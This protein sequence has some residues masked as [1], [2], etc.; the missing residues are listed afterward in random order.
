MRGQAAERLAAA[1][2]RHRGYV[3]EAANVRFRMG[4]LD[5]I[6]L[7]EET[8]CFIEVRSVGSGRFGSALESVN[9]RKQAHL[10]RAARCYLQR[11]RPIWTGPVRFDVVAIQSDGLSQARPTLVRGAFDASDLLTGPGPLAW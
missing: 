6:G 1:F 7:E 4:E 8:M 3:I 9:P 5:L 10:I 2:L 11:R